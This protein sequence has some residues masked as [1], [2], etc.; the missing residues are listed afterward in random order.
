MGQGFAEPL[1]LVRGAHVVDGWSFGIGAGYGAQA[2]GRPTGPAA[3][4]Y[5]HLPGG[6]LRGL[7]VTSRDHSAAAVAESHRFRSTA[8][9]VAV[10]T[11][12]GRPA[13]RRPRAAVRPRPRSPGR[14]DA[15]QSRAAG[16]DDVRRLA[17]RAGRRPAPP[18]GRRDAR[19][20]VIAVGTGRWQRTAPGTGPVGRDRGRRGPRGDGPRSTRPW[21]SATSSASGEPGRG[22]A[23]VFGDLPYPDDD[24]L[25][26][27]VLLLDDPEVVVEVVEDSRHGG[28]GWWRFAAHD[29]HSLRHLAVHPDRWGTAL[30]REGFH[31]AEAAGARRL[32]VLFEANTHARGLYESLG[33]AP[34]GDHQECPWPP[35]P[36]ELEYAAPS[37]PRA[38]SR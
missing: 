17:R 37:A 26:R 3:W 4:T 31:R 18:G 34:N 27:W 15:G 12:V 16:P 2:A 11:G 9:R 28:A 5:D 13:H 24:V 21:P 1:P 8:P 23:H 38:A 29:G 14:V 7:V 10:L 36:T 35:Y 19:R 33:W 25:A 30:G 6:V 22:L 20:V 32:W